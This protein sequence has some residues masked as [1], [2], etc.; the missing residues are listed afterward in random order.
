MSS[1]SIMHIRLSCAV[2][3]HNSE[4]SHSIKMHLDSLRCGNKMIHH[5]SVV[6]IRAGGGIETY[7]SSLLQFPFSDMSNCVLTSL[8]DLDQ[9]QFKLLHIHG[10]QLFEELRGECPTI[11]TLHNHSTYCPSG[12]KYLAT[13]EAPCDRNMSY[14]RCTWGHL[15]DSC[16]S[17]RPQNIISNLRD[18]RHEFD[19][20]KRLKIPIIANSDY[21]RRQL[22]ENGFPSEQVLTLRCGVAFPQADAQPLIQEIHQNQRILFV[23]RI[24]PEKGLSWL[25]K[26]LKLTDPQIQ[27][28]IAG[29][30][31]A[32]PQMQKLA[33]QLG[34]SDRV[35]W[36]GWCNGEKL[37][38]LYSQCFSVIFPS[39][40][41]EPAGLI[42]LE[43]H[44]RYRPVIASSVGGIPEYM[45]HGETGILVAA[46]DAQELSEAIT[47]L[48]SSYRKSRIMGERGHAW[49]LEEFTI[50]LHVERLRKL[51]EKTISNFHALA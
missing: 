13:S 26:A 30:G 7:L 33:K 15:V 34:L 46:N 27:L 1:S 12:T 49:V 48:S 40:W 51:Y 17:K 47:E 3:V 22:I 41:P 9:S 50:D 18:S 6:D 29:E 2:A 36:H 37:E 39:I 20:L 10:Q 23:G 45:R 44:A 38:A 28:D 43:A 19:T 31:R 5:C 14:L 42:T 4:H 11:Y 35:T 32:R 24:V 25:L 21:V 16:G 8:K